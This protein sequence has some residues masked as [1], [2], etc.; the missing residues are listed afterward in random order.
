MPPKTLLN[1]KNL[2]ISFADRQVLTGLTLSVSRGEIVAIVG[3]NGCG[4]STILNLVMEHYRHS[5][6]F[7]DSNRIALS[8]TIDLAHRIGLSYLPQNLRS[9]WSAESFQP[10]DYTQ[11]STESRL[12]EAFG[13]DGGDRSPDMLSDGQL[14]KLANIQTLTSTADLYLLDEPTSHLDIE[15]IEILESLLNAFRGGFLIISHDRAFVQ[16]VAD[17]LFLIKQGKI[18]QV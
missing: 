11:A 18:R 15:S 13:F 1:I 14:Q 16:T 10:T 7:Q 8:G 12:K 5:T 9:D 17:K 2:D 3:A 6:E 4:K